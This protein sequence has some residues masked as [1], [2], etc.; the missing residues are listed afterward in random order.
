MKTNN[1][2]AMTRANAAAVAA[3]RAHEMP[4]A[5][6]P[7]PDRLLN[8]KQVLERVGVSYVTVWKW[9][10][11]GKFPQSRL[12]GR[13]IFWFESEI[14]AWIANRP[15]RGRAAT[16]PI[17]AKDPEATLQNLPKIGGAA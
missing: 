2:K 10:G 17:R 7:S 15:V 13:Q 1:T 9:M 5:S 16:T 6:M 8:K 11:D 4:S 12:V 14:A 3:M